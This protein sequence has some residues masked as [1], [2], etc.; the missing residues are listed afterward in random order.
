V[1]NIYK[2]ER[3]L[4]KRSR[5][6]MGEWKLSKEEFERCKKETVE[7]TAEKFFPDIERKVKM[8]LCRFFEELFNEFM[9]GERE[10]YL[11][12]EEKDKGNGNREL[13]FKI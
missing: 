13:I 8:G 9:V 5:E 10:R 4:K 3:N 7:K 2:R 12:K 6:R 11:E 1:P